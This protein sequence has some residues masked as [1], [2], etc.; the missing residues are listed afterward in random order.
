MVRS[1]FAILRLLSLALIALPLWSPSPAQA[2]WQRCANQ[3]ETCRFKGQALVRYGAEG[4]YTYQVARN[5]ILC[6][7]RDFGSDPAQGVLKQCAYTYDLNQRDPGSRGWTHC[8]RENEYC[9]VPGTARMRYGVDGRYVY[10]DV[11]GGVQCSVHVFGDPAKGQHKT[12]EYQGGGRDPGNGDGGRGWE[13]CGSE[14]GFCSFRGPGEV[15]YGIN[16]RFIVR[17]AINGMPCSLSAFGQ[18]PAIGEH[19]QCFVRR[20]GG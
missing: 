8:A 14:G 11:T 18:D 16:G 12:C 9:R 7:V 20:G 5:R 6:D 19:K 3:D 15:R 2:Q 17:R 10:R 4:R 1:T 13:Y